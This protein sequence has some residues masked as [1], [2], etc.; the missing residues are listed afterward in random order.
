LATDE[1]G[2]CTAA[3]YVLLE[4]AEEFTIVF[5]S[6]CITDLCLGAD[7]ELGSCRSVVNGRCVRVDVTRGYRFVATEDIKS[8][9]LCFVVSLQKVAVGHASLLR[10][11]CKGTFDGVGGQVSKEWLKAWIIRLPLYGRPFVEFEADIL[12]R[13]DEV[14]ELL[15]GVHEIVVDNGAID[16]E[17]SM[18]IV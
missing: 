4:C 7:V 16:K 5:A 18:N 11:F 3:S 17:G 9:E 14:F 2:W 15:V 8:W 1:F 6:I 10:C 12:G 13:D